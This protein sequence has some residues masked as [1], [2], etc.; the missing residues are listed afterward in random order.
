M[1]RWNAIVQKNERIRIIIIKI[2]KWKSSLIRAQKS[3]KVS[4][5]LKGFN[6]FSRLRKI[7]MENIR[8]LIWK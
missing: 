6:K 8:K 3:L 7:I 1:D 4:L 2:I 5:I